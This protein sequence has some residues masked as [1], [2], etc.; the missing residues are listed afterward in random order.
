MC[1]ALRFSLQPVQGADCQNH[2]MS[3]VERL[4]PANSFQEWISLLFEMIEQTLRLP[5]S[6]F[7]YL[8]GQYLQHNKIREARRR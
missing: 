8:D 7:L 3:G 6:D 5:L 4:R 2:M 1:G